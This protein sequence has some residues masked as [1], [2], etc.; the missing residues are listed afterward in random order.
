M[1]Y[2]AMSLHIFMAAFTVPS[3][4]SVAA[5]IVGLETW[6]SNLLS[7]QQRGSSRLLASF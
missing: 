7:M 2:F 3:P 4:T 5:G 6:S 1:I